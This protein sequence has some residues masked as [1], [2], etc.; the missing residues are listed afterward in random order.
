MWGFPPVRVCLAHAGNPRVVTTAADLSRGLSCDGSPAPTMTDMPVDPITPEEM[1]ELMQRIVEAT[2]PVRRAK[3]IREAQRVSA[4]SL[5]V[6]WDAAVFEASRDMK[7]SA[8]RVE[9]GYAD[10]TA[11]EE[12]IRRHLRRH[13]EAEGERKPAGRPRKEPRQG[14]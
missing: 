12:P 7:N 8:L 3:L 5:A 9:L 1:A 2:D 13:P 10:D 4:A 6:A 14:A 11:V